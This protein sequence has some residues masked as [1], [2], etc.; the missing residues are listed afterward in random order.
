[1]PENYYCEHKLKQMSL[2]YGAFI[3][4][5]QETD[6]AYYLQL[7]WPTRGMTNLSINQNIFL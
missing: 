6:Q 5:S 4:S 3:P 7:L 2:A 1:M